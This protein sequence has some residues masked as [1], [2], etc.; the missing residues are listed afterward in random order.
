MVVDFPCTDSAAHAPTEAG[1]KNKSWRSLLV[2][3]SWTP[4]DSVVR[5]P[6][7]TSCEEVSLR[8][9]PSEILR[10]PQPPVKVRNAGWASTQPRKPFPAEAS[11]WAAEELNWR[12]TKPA[13]HEAFLSSADAGRM[14][15]GVPTA[16][17]VR[18]RPG[19]PQLVSRLFVRISEE[20]A[21]W[22]T[23]RIPS[24]L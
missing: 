9:F 23:R 2:K 10:D 21:L 17:P 22:E 16:V 12:V 6:A 13:G 8:R 4:S 5:Q 3:S 19:F 18:G 1:W 7:S 11:S 24:G 14:F 15:P 20:T